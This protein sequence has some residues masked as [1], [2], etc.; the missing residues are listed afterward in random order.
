MSEDV[1]I[2]ICIG[3]ASLFCGSLGFVVNRLIKEYDKKLDELGSRVAS[4]NALYW[5]LAER[6]AKLEISHQETQK[7]VTIIF[8]VLD[9]QNPRRP[10]KD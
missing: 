3:L 10:R 8:T 5:G 2:K 7:D 4:I 6:V 9:D 1:L